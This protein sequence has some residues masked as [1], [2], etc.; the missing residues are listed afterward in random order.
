M[1]PFSAP[2][3]KYFDSLS[4]EDQVKLLTE[5]KL[6]SQLPKIIKT[7]YEGLML[8]HYFTAGHGEV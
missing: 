1:I 3:E 5:K 4:E 2:F 7:G 8:T 6:K